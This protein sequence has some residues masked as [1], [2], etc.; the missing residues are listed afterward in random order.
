MDFA[1]K[2]FGPIAL[3]GLADAELTLVGWGS[4][5]SI[6]KHVLG[7]FNKAGAKRVNLL[8]MRYLHPFPAQEVTQA[9]KSARRVLAIECNYSGQL[10]RLI[11]M[12]T[13]FDIAERFLKY[14][15]E[16]FSQGSTIARVQEMLHAGV[17]A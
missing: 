13:G 11:R 8:C 1:L 14:D 12:E 7:H 10:C 2:D 16:P 17:C 3:E 4:T 9:L 6:M 15:G 5:Y